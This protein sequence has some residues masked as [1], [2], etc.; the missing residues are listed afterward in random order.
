MLFRCG[1]EIVIE[2][3][4][5]DDDYDYDGAVS[6]LETLPRSIVPLE[7]ACGEQTTIS[8]VDNTLPLYGI[9]NSERL[10]T[11]DYDR[12]FADRHRGY[13]VIDLANLVGGGLTADGGED[14]DSRKGVAASERTAAGC[15][16]SD[17]V[18]SRN[19]HLLKLGIAA[20]LIVCVSIITAALLIYKKSREIKAT[21]D[22]EIQY[23]IDYEMIP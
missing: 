20:I 8:G 5:R 1:D 17:R 2:A 6:S 22:P 18:L 11:S 23:L 19:I 14:A 16:D 7:I 3:L 15:F 12:D 21:S 13:A 9:S 10:P 4:A